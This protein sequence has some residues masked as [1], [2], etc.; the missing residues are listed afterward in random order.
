MDGPRALTGGINYYR[1]QNF[2]GGFRRITKLCFPEIQT[3]TLIL[4][5]EDA[6]VLIPSTIGRAEDLVQDLTLRFLPGVGHWIQQ[7]APEEVNEMLAAWLTERLV[8]GSA[9][10]NSNAH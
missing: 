7:E 3:P 10:L 5:G 1:A 4:W 2:G 6:P 8:P 9:T